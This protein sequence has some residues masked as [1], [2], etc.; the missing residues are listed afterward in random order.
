MVDCE[1]SAGV[2]GYSDRYAIIKLSST[3]MFDYT[4]QSMSPVIKDHRA[5]TREV[6]TL[7]QG[8]DILV[9]QAYLVNSFDEDISGEDLD[10]IAIYNYSS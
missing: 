7:T 6:R 3:E 1:V 8:N 2:S 5:L 9:I 10:Y 4:W